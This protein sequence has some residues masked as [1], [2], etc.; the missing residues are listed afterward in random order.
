M[1]MHDFA[2]KG[3]RIH[4]GGKKH[5]SFLRTLF[6]IL[7]VVS[8]SAF[9]AVISYLNNQEYCLALSYDGEEIATVESEETYE[10]V[11]QMIRT[12]SSESSSKTRYAHYSEYK[13]TVV[14]SAV[15]SSVHDVK[16]KIIAQS[17]GELAE[18]SGIYADGLFVVAVEEDAADDLV[19]EVKFDATFDD[20]DAQT[21]FIE[22]VEIVRGL[23]PPED[24]K[25][26][27]EAKEILQSGVT[28]DVDYVVEDG[29]TIESIADKFDVTVDEIENANKTGEENSISPG[30]KLK[31]K[32]KRVP[33][34]I[35]TVRVQE[36]ITEIPFEV[37]RVPEDGQYEGWEKTEVEGEN[38]A[39]SVVT[40]IVYINGE[41]KNR[42]EVKREI[43]K[44]PVKKRV[45]FGTKKKPVPAKKGQDKGSSGGVKAP[46]NGKLLWPVPYTRNVTS[47]YGPRE[48]EFHKGIDIASAGIRGQNIVAAGD[49]VVEF[50]GNGGG[51]GNYVKISHGSGVYTLYAHCEDLCVKAGQKVTCGDVIGHVGTTGRSTGYHVHF[52]VIVNGSKVNPC[53]FV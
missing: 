38:G 39:E 47:P 42:Q 28:E 46:S 16:S 36:E 21:K 11:D 12:C 35:E 31:V 32:V 2:D 37:E 45:L 5:F 52:E 29:D 23:Y 24:V 26:L 33:V 6:G 10:Q 22:N 43:V 25:S 8:V 34:H 48:G 53:D 50:A 49:G 51:Y 19:A 40:K 17:N 1:L 44:E 20:E 9:V 18:A 15:Y 4:V 27:D 41:E 13:L 14:K 7:P 3:L 30:D